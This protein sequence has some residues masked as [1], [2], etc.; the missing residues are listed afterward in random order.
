MPAWA[1]LARL[2]EFL[3]SLAKTSREAFR[4]AIMAKAMDDKVDEDAGLGGAQC[5]GGIVDRDRSSIRE[6]AGFRAADEGF[7]IGQRISSSDTYQLILG[8]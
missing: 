1:G 2:L 6:A 5:S 8:Q 7:E 3:S 4:Q